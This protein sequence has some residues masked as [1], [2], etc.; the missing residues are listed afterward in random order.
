[1][2]TINIL[3]PH[4][5]DR[6]RAAAAT[7]NAIEAEG[8]KWGVK[9]HWLGDFS[10]EVTGPGITGSVSVQEGHVLLKVDMTLLL[11]QVL[12][13]KTLEDNLLARLKDA[14]RP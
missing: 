10:A 13:P 11:R 3:H 5:L 8:K 1:M 7:R 9:V 12:P 2:S 4:S 6:K 14:L